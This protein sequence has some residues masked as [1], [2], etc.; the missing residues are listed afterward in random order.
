[1]NESVIS[2]LTRRKGS[3]A[4]LQRELRKAEQELRETARARSLDDNGFWPRAL[5]ANLSLLEALGGGEVGKQRQAEIVAAYKAAMELGAARR[6]R[7]SILENMRF[8]EAIASAG[9]AK[10]KKAAK[11]IAGIRE[12]LEEG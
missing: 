11:A 4:A 3:P 10:A 12:A 2:V 6:E 1:M 5:E 7:L 9:N 8:L